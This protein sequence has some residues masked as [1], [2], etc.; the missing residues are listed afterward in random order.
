[1]TA[2]SQCNSLQDALRP[3]INSHN[4]PADYFQWDVPA[5]R[6]T[7]YRIGGPMACSAH[8]ASLDDTIALCQALFKHKLTWSATLGWGSNTIVASQGISGITLITRKMNWITPLDDH[9]FTVGAGVHLAKLA[10]FA[11][12]AGLSGAE[13]M[14][15]IPGT[16]G[17][18]ARMN[19]GAMRQET[20]GIVQAIRLFNWETGTVELW[21]IEA[22]MYAYRSSALD[23]EKHTVLEATIALTPGDTASIR[24]AMD[25]NLAF[26]KTH[27][28]TEP[29]GGSVFKNPYPPGHANA[30]QTAGWMLDQLGARGTDT[31]TPWAVGGSSVSPKH[32][33]FIINTGEATSLDVLQLMGRMQDAISQAYGVRLHPENLVLG[34]LTPEERANWAQLTA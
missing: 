14:I 4:W 5:A 24:A 10:T 26:R 25:A 32:A 31:T 29:N 20:S 16:M 9:R 2:L 3:V 15:G 13:F 30:S 17:G 11:C 28:P 18:A 8:P 19:A 33:N 6:Y 12:D 21:C 27:H 7:T 22:L 1:M 23:P 34:D